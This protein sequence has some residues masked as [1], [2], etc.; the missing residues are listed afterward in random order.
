M[1]VAPRTGRARALAS[2][3]VAAALAYTH[4]PP[5][6]RR[7]GDASED[8]HTH[9]RKRART[10]ANA[11]AERGACEGKKADKGAGGA[12]TV[13]LVSVLARPDK[14]EVAYDHSHGARVRTSRVR[15]G[16]GARQAVLD[17][18]AESALQALAAEGRLGDA[19]AAR[20]A[21]AGAQAAEAAVYARATSAATYRNAAAHALRSAPLAFVRAEDRSRAREE[22]RAAGLSVRE[23]EARGLA[24]APG[25]GSHAGVLRAA[26]VLRA[27]ERERASDDAHTR[28]A[29]HEHR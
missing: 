18:L 14:P 8:A 5:P 28:T 29:G 17:R 20:E 4:A 24:P 7:A 11:P 10:H 25:G 13:A 21:L 15:V 1:P 3:R 23:A 22:M 26:E 19:D 12:T 16:V 2:A 6:Q 27:R 9:T